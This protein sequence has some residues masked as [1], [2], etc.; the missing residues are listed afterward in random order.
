M[1]DAGIAIFLNVG[2]AAVIA[3]V[4]WLW[5]W[6]GSPS[7]SPPRWVCLRCGTTDDLAYYDAG[8]TLVE[9]FL[10]C[11]ALLPGFLYHLWRNSNSYYACSCC[12]SND[13]VPEDS[14]RAKQA[15]ATAREVLRQ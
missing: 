3:G 4:W 7:A 8:S 5:R 13:L 10:W 2:L 15:A 1:S 12:G 9:I 11:V 14:P 6:S